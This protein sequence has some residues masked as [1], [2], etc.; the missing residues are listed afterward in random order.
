M[1]LTRL[2][3][4]YDLV[5]KPFLLREY[6]LIFFLLSVDEAALFS[7][8]LGENIMNLIALKSYELKA[9]CIDMRFYERPQ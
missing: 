6:F 9:L 7:A 3:I 8:L 2:A 1:A 4:C 5:Q